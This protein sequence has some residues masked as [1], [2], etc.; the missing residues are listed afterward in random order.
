MRKTVHSKLIACYILIGIIGFLFATAGGSHFVESYL[1]G[2]VGHRLYDG[3]TRFAS[4]EI[5]KTQITE[6][7]KEGLQKLVDILASGEEAG[8]L[9]FDE[10]AHVLV[11]SFN[12]ASRMA[13]SDAKSTETDFARCR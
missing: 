8:V 4:D 13:V 3:A 9:L 6:A 7:D 5:A 11:H 10:N 2:E 12:I 1:E